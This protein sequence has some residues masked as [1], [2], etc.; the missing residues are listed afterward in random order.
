MTYISLYKLR[1]KVAQLE[2]KLDRPITDLEKA[3]K[4]YREIEE[5]EAEIA[6]RL[7]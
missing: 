2:R 4:I 1:R 3:R 7:T 6:R 5:L